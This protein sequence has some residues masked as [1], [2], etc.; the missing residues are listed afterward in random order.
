M[1]IY[2]KGYYTPTTKES[3]WF[4]IWNL[5]RWI[6]FLMIFQLNQGQN[7]LFL[8]ISQSGLDVAQN[9]IQQNK[10]FKSLSVPYKYVLHIGK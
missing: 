8:G 2:K 9:F 7:E 3:S 4:E 5:W 6:S 1:V 10:N